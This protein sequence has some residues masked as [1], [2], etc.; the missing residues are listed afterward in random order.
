MWETF[1]L[2]LIIGL[3]AVASIRQAYLTVI[4]KKTNCSCSENNCKTC[5]SPQ[6]GDTKSCQSG[7]PNKAGPSDKKA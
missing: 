6:S 7:K 2:W 4:G 5:R 1:V 3:A